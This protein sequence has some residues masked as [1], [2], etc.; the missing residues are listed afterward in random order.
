MSAS[1]EEVFTIEIAER[2]DWNDCICFKPV[3]HMHM[4]F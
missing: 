2:I 4:V 1:T 3:L